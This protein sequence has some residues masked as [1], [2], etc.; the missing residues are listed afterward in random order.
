MNPQDPLAQL[1][2][3][4]LPNE[5]S[6]W[7]PAPGWWIV[8][9]LLLLALLGLAAWLWRQRQ[10]R[11][12]RRFA[13]AE[14][15]TARDAFEESGDALHYAQQLNLILKRAALTAWP[16]DEVANLSGA[17]WMSFLDQQWPTRYQGTRFVDSGLDTL[18]YAGHAQAELAESS[19]EIAASWLN[20]HS[21]GR[22]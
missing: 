22:S 17:Q 7:P 11:A 2:D 10:R 19:A 18:P 5:I 8:A 4:Q 1:R 6:W 13:V 9:A 15:L 14:L 21:A 12:Y 16:H 20:L 3:I